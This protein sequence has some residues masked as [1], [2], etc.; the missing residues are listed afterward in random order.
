M[1]SLI[2]LGLISILI[3]FTLWRGI[4]IVD[5]THN[6]VVERLGKYHKT[7]KAGL[8]FIIPYLD[9]IPRGGK[10]DIRERSLKKPGDNQSDP[11]FRVITSDN[12]QIDIKV[13][14]LFR[15]TKVDNYFFRN[16]DQE[17]S[18]YSVINGTVRSI[19]GKSTLDEVNT[20]R[21]V[22]SN[23]I[24][25]NLSEVSDE[26]GIKVTRVEILEVEVDQETKDAM[27]KQLNAERE[28][29]ASVTKA[30][31]DKK[32]LELN[33]EAKL[34]EAQKEAE[35]VKAKADAQAYAVK[36]VAE[37]IEKNGKSAIEFETK[38]I[39]ADAIKELGKGSSSKIILLPNDL[40]QSFQ[41]L[42]TNI[43]K[44]K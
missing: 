12:V 18:I 32:S 21:D 41:H 11:E 15:I 3:I 43:L 20:N 42:L 24:S 28:R 1:E 44:K 39:E 4:Y 30:E 27:Q 36:V 34:F 16:K 7:M 35:A 23:K 37:A 40:L 19:L 13:A 2:I 25:E 33:A 14:M 17:S 10:I 6:F 9:S 38:K 29:R 31:G 22:M 5:Q 26:W 8:N